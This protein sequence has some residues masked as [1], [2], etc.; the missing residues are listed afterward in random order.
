MVIKITTEEFKKLRELIYD[1]FGINLSDSKKN[2]VN[3]RLQKVLHS[4]GFKNFKEYLQCLQDDKTSQSISELINKIS[5]NHTY[6]FR[7]EKHFDYLTQ[8]VMPGI[9]QAL[10]NNNSRDIRVWCAGCATGEEAYSL[11]ICML[12]FFGKEYK[13]WSGGVL[14]TDISERALNFAQQGVY[15]DEK[16]KKMPLALRNKYFIRHTAGTWKVSDELRKEVT[17]RRFNLMNPQ[18]PFKKPFQ[19]VFCRNV[20]IYFDNNV[21]K[22]LVS[23]FYHATEADGYLFIGHSETLGRNDCLYEYIMPAV[24]KKTR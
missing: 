13:S 4:R 9:A 15:T 14:A 18:F 11:V 19:A 21:R 7:E 20:M 23:R 5:T 22:K 8:S 6:F 10:E 12:E 17:F 3:G 24:Y 1:R 2:L 16:L